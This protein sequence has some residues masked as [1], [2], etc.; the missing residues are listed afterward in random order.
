MYNLDDI[1]LGRLNELEYHPQTLAQLFHLINSIASFRGI[2]DQ[3]LAEV[4][5]TAAIT[6]SNEGIQYLRESV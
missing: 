6:L 1:I 3:D 4:V 5:A 2:G